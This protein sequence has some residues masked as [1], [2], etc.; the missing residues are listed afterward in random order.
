[1]QKE[2]RRSTYPTCH[3]RRARATEQPDATERAQE[4]KQTHAKPH[5][6]RPVPRSRPSHHHPTSRPRRAAAV[7]AV[8]ASDGEDPQATALSAAPARCGNVITAAAAQE[9]GP[10]L[11]PRPTAPQPPPTGSKP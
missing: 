8:A 10:P 5:A 2:N 6:S 7:F 4:K 1:M 3:E 9:E 11:P